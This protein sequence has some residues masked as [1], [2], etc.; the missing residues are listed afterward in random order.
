EL[1]SVV[2]RDQIERLP[3]NG[4]N[5]MSFSVI[6][7]GVSIDHTPQ[8]GV[9]TTYGLSFTGQRGRSN[10]VMVDGLDNNDPVVGA[11]RATF[12]QEAVREFQVLTNSYSA[13]FGKASGGVVNI[14]TK[15]GTNEISGNAFAFVRDDSLNAKDHFE[16]F[17]V[18]GGAID[19]EKAPYKQWQYGATLGGPNRKD[20]TFFFLSFE[21]LDISA[22]NFVTISDADA[23]VLG[24][25]G[26]PAPTGG[27]TT[28]VQD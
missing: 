12:S 22:N 28:H 25:A 9:T 13:E 1:S 14:V 10:N 15:S 4:R 5:F 23:A 6:T 2:S 24:R 16:Q 7:P 19:R 21:R 20:K 11:V 3:S 17:D 26:F 27:Y 18:F 8:Q